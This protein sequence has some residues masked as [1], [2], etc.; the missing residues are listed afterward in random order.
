MKTIHC[1][2]TKASRIFVTFT[3]V[4]CKN[5]RIQSKKIQGISPVYQ[6]IIRSSLSL[7]YVR[8]IELLVNKRDPH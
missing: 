7:I 5:M 8:S 3:E 6:R 2:L 4:L 1:Y